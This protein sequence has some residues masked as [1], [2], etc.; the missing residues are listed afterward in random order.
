MFLHAP[1]SVAQVFDYQG[2]REATGIPQNSWRLC[3]KLLSW[4]HAT[5]IQ[6][7][8]PWANIATSKN[9]STKQPVDH[10]IYV[11]L[12]NH[13]PNQTFQ[14]TWLLEGMVAIST[15]TTTDK[16]YQG[17]GT[18]RCCLIISVGCL[19][20]IQVSQH[21]KRC[22]HGMGYFL[23]WLGAK[24]HSVRQPPGSTATQLHLL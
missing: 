10:W 19:R 4:K 20:Y 9:S 17:H 15:W 12:S 23:L 22:G 8:H 14:I 16:I 6:G 5:T 18:S 3:S 21:W 7:H 2:S 11:G 1:S 24:C 13:G